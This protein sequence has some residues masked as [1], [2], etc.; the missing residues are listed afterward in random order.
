[1]QQCV[2]VLRTGSVSHIVNIFYA[3]CLVAVLCVP[4][5]SGLQRWHSL[6]R[7]STECKPQVI[8][9]QVKSD[10]CVNISNLGCARLLVKKNRKCR[11][12]KCVSVQIVTTVSRST[13][14]V[15][16]KVQHFYSTHFN[17]LSHSSVH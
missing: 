5:N 3:F 15:P 12:T 10:S 11:N 4:P 9:K 2:V 17:P 13:D 6:A 1:M 7:A 14:F 16:D 8:Q